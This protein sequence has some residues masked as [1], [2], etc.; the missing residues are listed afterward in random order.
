MGSPSLRGAPACDE[1]VRNIARALWDNGRVIWGK[2][3]EEIARADG[4]AA[5]FEF[6]STSPEA[7]IRYIHRQLEDADLYFVANRKEEAADV[8]ATFRVS[9]KQPELWGPERGTI[10]DLPDWTLTD[11]GRTL[12]PL[13][14]EPLESVFVVFRGTASPSSS[15]FAWTWSGS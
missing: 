8:A 13:R 2:T 10:R 6:T 5:D 1:E 12:V 7:D 3:F 14:L 11:D 4:L 9:G 15:K